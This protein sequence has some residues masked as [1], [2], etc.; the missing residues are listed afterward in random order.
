VFTPFVVGDDIP[1]D[2]RQGGLGSTG[3]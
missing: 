2:E 3:A 1:A